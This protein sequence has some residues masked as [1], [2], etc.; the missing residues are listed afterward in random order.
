MSD[1]SMTPQ[2]RPGGIRA[3]GRGRKAPGARRGALTITAWSAAG[4]TLLGGAGLGYVYFQLDG[5]LKGVDI[6]AALGTDRPH[7]VD[8]GSMDILLMGSDSRA[9]ANGKYGDDGSGERADT[10]MVLHVHKGHKKASVVSIPRDTMVGRPECK[11]PSGG[12]SPAVERGMF[13]ESYQAGGPACAVKTV[14]KMSGIRMDHYVEVDFTGFKKLINELGGVPVDTSEPIKDKSSKLDLQPGKHTLD[15]E[16]ALGLVRTRHAVGDGSDLGRIQ[17]QQ[18]F[19]KALIS[20]VKHVDVFG[21]PGKLYGLAD[22]ATRTVTTDSE[23]SSVNKLVSFTK[24]L[25]GIEGN[26]MNMVT[27]PVNYDKDDP[28]RVLPMEK[29]S[30]EVWNALLHDRPVPKSATK[31]TAGDRAG[32]TG[33]VKSS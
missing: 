22:T 14:E 15:G 11:K 10:A 23:L 31:G 21:D 32:A 9:G 4:L 25:K 29:Q 20:Q 18:A 12:T 13:N 19:L 8:N 6:N 1:E 17:L 3:T 24:G 28:N 7:N 16:Q 26:D 5:N 27:L 30:R 33:V 2:E